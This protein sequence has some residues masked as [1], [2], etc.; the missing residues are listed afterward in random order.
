[1]SENLQYCF[2]MQ[3][4]LNKLET[5]LSEDKPLSNIDS[6]KIHDAWLAVKSMSEHLGLE[7]Q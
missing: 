3:N 7:D 6:C 4:I 5:E 1:M 2:E